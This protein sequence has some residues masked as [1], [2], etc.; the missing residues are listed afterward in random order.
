MRVYL[1]SWEGR[2]QQ[3]EEILTLTLTDAQ[4]L[5]AALNYLV[6]TAERR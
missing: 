6:E 1:R 3:F 4:E 2:E 5:A